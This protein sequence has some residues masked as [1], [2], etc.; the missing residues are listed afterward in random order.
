MKIALQ[1]PFVSSLAVACME[2][3]LFDADY[4]R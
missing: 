1:L 2:D 3:R 4:E